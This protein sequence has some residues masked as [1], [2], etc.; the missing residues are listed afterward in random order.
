LSGNDN[1]HNKLINASNVTVIFLKSV[2]IVCS[3]DKYSI[4]AGSRGAGRQLPPGIFFAPP[5]PSLPPMAPDL[6][7]NI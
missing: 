1:K 6:I 5:G 2:E 7:T 4:G 3:L